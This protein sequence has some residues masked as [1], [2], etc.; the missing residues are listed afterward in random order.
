MIHKSL[1]VG[2]CFIIVSNLFVSVVITANKMIPMLP[3][4]MVLMLPTYNASDLKK[5]L[6]GKQG[7]EPCPSFHQALE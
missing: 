1:T 3:G 5:M 6:Q 2:D 7:R 4:S